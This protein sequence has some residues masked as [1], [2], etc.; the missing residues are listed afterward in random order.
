MRMIAAPRRCKSAA[1]VNA[2]SLVG[3]GRK[4]FS[5]QVPASLKTMVHSVMLAA[6]QAMHPTMQRPASWEKPR[7]ATQSAPRIGLTQSARRPAGALSYW[8]PMIRLTITPE[9]YEAIA[10]TLPGNV[11]IE[12][13]ARP[14]WRR[15][16]LA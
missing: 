9:A 6:P 12:R 1:C 11:G 15:L 13:G 2:A 16:H 4:C 5:S 14:E 7:T 10:A 3:C 8:P